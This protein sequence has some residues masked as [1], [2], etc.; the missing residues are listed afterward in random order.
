MLTPVFMM[1]PAVRHGANLPTISYRRD[2]LTQKEKVKN[3]III[4]RQTIL[5]HH[6][7]IIRLVLC[8]NPIIIK[9]PNIQL[10]LGTLPDIAKQ[11]IV[12]RNSQSTVAGCT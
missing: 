5:L 3:N 6:R 4:M 1:Q 7:L 11:Q 9:L 10:T 8:W 12:C 2:R